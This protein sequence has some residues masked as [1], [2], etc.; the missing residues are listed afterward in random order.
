V[1]DPSTFTSIPLSGR[2]KLAKILQHGYQPAKNVA[3]LP[4]YESPNPVN[5][6]QGFS[7]RPFRILDTNACR[8]ATEYL[9]CQ[10]RGAASI[11]VGPSGFSTKQVLL[12]L[13]TNN[14]FG[15]P[16]AD[17]LLDSSSYQLWADQVRDFFEQYTPN[18]SCQEDSSFWQLFT[19]YSCSI[20]TTDCQVLDPEFL[21]DL[22]GLP[23]DDD[24]VLDAYQDFVD[25]WGH[26]S[27]ESFSFGV[28]E[29]KVQLPLQDSIPT[30]Y[31]GRAGGNG[32]ITAGE[33]YTADEC[34]D[35]APVTPDYQPWDQVLGD[36]FM[37]EDENEDEDAEF[38][39]NLDAIAAN[40][41]TL[42]RS[43]PFLSQQVRDQGLTYVN[44]PLLD[45]PPTA[46]PS[47]AESSADPADTSTTTPT[48][49]PTTTTLWG[50]T[51]APS[52][53]T[54]EEEVPTA[55]PS[56]TTTIN[57]PGTSDGTTWKRLLYSSFALMLW[58]TVWCA[59]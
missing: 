14:E 7:D 37:Y 33:Y 12:E 30:L 47:V 23:I 19:S 35:P 41:Q 57:E 56:S 9:S 58:T 46:T 16:R 20:A 21:Q 25:K 39:S 4:S 34:Q 44:C 18:D 15:A 51:T 48:Q 42:R 55:S 24:M 52:T 43:Y 3:T 59:I 38:L 13:G 17:V 49:A 54:A 36:L 45:T 26:G 31:M 22:K 29:W 2:P 6:H 1:T 50:T 32:N 53:T 10:R 5:L 8:F 11:V 28:M 27:V 40:F